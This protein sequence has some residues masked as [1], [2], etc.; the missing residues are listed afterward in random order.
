MVIHIQKW[1]KN[2]FE[3]EWIKKVGFGSITRTLIWT[4]FFLFLIGRLL[5]PDP[6]PDSKIRYADSLKNTAVIPMVL[7]K[8][9]PRGFRRDLPQKSTET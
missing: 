3:G 1:V 4:A 5:K 7:P 9:D 8:S 2:N 6:F